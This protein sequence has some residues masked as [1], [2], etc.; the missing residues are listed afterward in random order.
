MDRCKTREYYTVHVYA[1]RT[2]S[3][4]VWILF[5]EG[6]IEDNCNISNWQQHLHNWTAYA[7]IRNYGE[8]AVYMTFCAGV[9]MT[10]HCYQSNR[11]TTFH[12]YEPLI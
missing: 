4:H 2:A 10:V 6:E 5:V 3:L 9:G 12:N 11:A 1:K 8:V 7:C